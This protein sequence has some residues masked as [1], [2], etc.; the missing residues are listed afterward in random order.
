MIEQ[1]TQLWIIDDDRSIRWVLEKA[2]EKEGLSVNT[3]DNGDTA[4]KQ[5][6]THQ[7]TAIIVTYAC[8]VSMAWIC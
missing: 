3:F 4:L 5:L 6:A 7:P 8:P 1:R 2:L